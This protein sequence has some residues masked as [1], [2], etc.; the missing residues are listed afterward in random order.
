MV[1]RI[2]PVAR[3]GAIRAEVL[4]ATGEPVARREGL[5]SL[6]DVHIPAD[7]AETKNEVVIEVEV[8][9][10]ERRDLKVWLFS[11]RVEVT[12]S[13]PRERPTSR[14]RFYRLEREYGGIRRVLFVPSAIR[15]EEAS[16]TLENG[17]LTITLKKLAARRRE[18]QLK[19]RGGE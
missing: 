16:A 17:I 6:A 2:K 14:T 15:S 10:V 18:I 19:I 3:K 5:A 11:N 9:G 7:I 12:G 13:K 1:R 8:P 4:S